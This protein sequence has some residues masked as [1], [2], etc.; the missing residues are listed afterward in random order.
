MRLVIQKVK[1]SNII[2]KEKTYAKINKGVLVFVGIEET[3]TSK[4]ID[5]AAKKITN[6]ELIP[7][8]N[9]KF[10]K[11]IKKAKEE[12]ML[13]PQFTLCANLIKNKISFS[14]AKKPKFARKMF[15]R[16]VEKLKTKGLKVVSGKFGSYMKIRYINDGPVN[17]Y[18]DTSLI[19]S[20]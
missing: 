4:D 15:D 16:L 11:N 10:G 19:S 6:L 2:V 3:D 7:Y 17:F 5:I 8:S 13:I 14:N 20:K 9:G 18:L 1:N 12:I